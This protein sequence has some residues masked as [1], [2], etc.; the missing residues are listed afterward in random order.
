M[1]KL[2]T[3]ACLMAL[4]MVLS[5]CDQDE[6]LFNDML[7]SARLGN[8]VAQFHLAELYSEGVGIDPDDRE[9][10]RWYEMSS[11]RGDALASYR[12]AR[13]HQGRAGAI[14]PADLD[15]AAR[16]YALSADAGFSDAQYEAGLLNRDRGDMVKAASYFQQAAKQGQVD[17]IRAL[18]QMLA[19]GEGTVRDL[20]QSYF[21]AQLAERLDPGLPVT[22]TRGIGDMSGMDMIPAAQEEVGKLVDEWRAEPTPV[23]QRAALNVDVARQHA[24][25]LEQ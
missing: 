21:Y 23:T 13:L 2:F 6:L 20:K 25:S 5:G 19:E 17:A 8:P 1:K 24:I 7:E 4:T 9:A 22:L 11:A 10:L 3:P 16:Y 15:K 18:S 14:I 12:L